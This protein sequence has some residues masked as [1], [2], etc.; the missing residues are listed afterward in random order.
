MQGHCKARV[1]IYH[2]RMRRHRK[3]FIM[4]LRKQKQEGIKIGSNIQI[5]SKKS[6]SLPLL[7]AMA[8]QAR[9]PLDKRSATQN[10][11]PNLILKIHQDREATLNQPQLF[12]KLKRKH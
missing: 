1:V 4:E 2:G 11:P 10:E 8:G 5:F 12:S 6:E 9:V 7:L 3:A